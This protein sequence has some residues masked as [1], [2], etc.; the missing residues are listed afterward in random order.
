MYSFVLYMTDEIAYLKADDYFFECID[1][2]KTLLIIFAVF[3]GSA[4]SLCMLMEE[5]DGT[6]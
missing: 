3:Q 2:K 6:P 5:M 1:D 4:A